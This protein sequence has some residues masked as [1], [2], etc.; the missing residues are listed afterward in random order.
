MVDIFNKYGT[1]LI[2]AMGQTLLLALYGLFFA[3]IIGLIVGIMSVKKISVLCIIALACI[4]GVIALPKAVKK[5]KRSA[6]KQR[7]AVFG[8]CFMSYNRVCGYP[9]HCRRHR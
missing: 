4:V 7:T 6:R 8:L 1:L 2:T 9:C 5:N 3:C